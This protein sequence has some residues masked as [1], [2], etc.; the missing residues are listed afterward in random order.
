MGDQ[1]AQS[2]RR[3]GDMYVSD[4]HEITCRH[5]HRQIVPTRYGRHMATSSFVVQ[6]T[7]DECELLE[8]VSR[9]DIAAVQPAVG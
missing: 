7:E 5:L 6:T 4:A 9:T 8:F 3:L 1:E 2:G